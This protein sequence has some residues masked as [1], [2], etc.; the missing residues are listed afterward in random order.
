MDRS[1]DASSVNPKM[2]SKFSMNPKMRSKFSMNPK[3][4]S[5]SSMNP[6]MSFQF[7]DEPQS[8]PSSQI[9]VHMNPNDEPQ[10]DQMNPK[11]SGPK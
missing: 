2:N 4:N 11:F 5:K 3:M 10:N 9:G 7:Y 8:E 6:K 1:L